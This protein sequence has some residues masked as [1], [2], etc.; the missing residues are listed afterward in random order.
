MAKL[1][2]Q[3]S[4]VFLV[5]TVLCFLFSSNVFASS[6][7]DESLII[8]LFQAA[9]GDTLDNMDHDL[10]LYNE[11]CVRLKIDLD[12]SKDD[13]LVT[14]SQLSGE[15]STMVESLTTTSEAGYTL[16]TTLGFEDKFFTVCLVDDIYDEES[17][18]WLV[19]VNGCVVY[20]AFG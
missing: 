2:K 20:D 19:I 13:A 18:V 10:S 3:L 6:E 1:I 4:A 5:C 12:F 7:L 11:N 9:M 16:L 8:P 14:K 15:Y 17:D